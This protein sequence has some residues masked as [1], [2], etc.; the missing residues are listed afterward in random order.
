MARINDIRSKLGISNLGDDDKSRLYQDFIKTGGKVID[1]Q[2][3]ENLE[4]FTRLK[5]LISSRDSY[6]NELEAR[7]EREFQEKQRRELTQQYQGRSG[8]TPAATPADKTKKKPDN[9]YFELFM[10]RIMLSV[11]SIAGFFSNRIHPQFMNQTMIDLKNALLNSRSILA[12]VLYQDRALSSQIKERLNAIA[13]HYYYELVFR[14]DTT[15]DDTHFRSLAGLKL[16]KRQLDNGG[17][18]FIALFKRLYLLAGYRQPLEDAVKTVLTAEG[19]M[20][21]ISKQTVESNIRYIS[22]NIDFIF[23]RYYPRLYQLVDYYYKKARAAGKKESLEE[24]I[25]FEE[26]DRV[27]YLTRKWQEEEDAEEKRRKQEAAKKLDEQKKSDNPASNIESLENN[28]VKQGLRLISANVNF[29]GVLE[30]AAQSNDPWGLCPVNDRVFLI[31]TLIDF[32]DREFSFLFVSNV[33]QY[34]IYID[35]YGAKIHMQNRLKDVYFQLEGVHQ[36]LRNYAKTLSQ[37]STSTSHKDLMTSKDIPEIA[38]LNAYREE[39]LRIVLLDSRKIF[40]NFVKIFEF[41][42]GDAFKKIIKNGDEVFE[43]RDK[44]NEP[45]MA[46]GKKINEIFLNAHYVAA[47]MFFLLTDADLSGYALFVKIP[48]YLS[49][50]VYREISVPGGKPNEKVKEALPEPKKVISPEEVEMVEDEIKKLND[51]LQSRKK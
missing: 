22:R 7:K 5:E 23:L 15:F 43:P 9:G 49:I 17:A 4:N 30:T 8:I 2:N 6:E 11:N 33:V 39:I 40:E 31:N 18:P 26:A 45:R 37:I 20:R 10:T 1:L 16:T 28:P 3:D 47:A 36:K 44:L 46:V 42:S 35:K 24:F 41:L 38:H 50:P 29:Q 25:R 27:G 32:F 51:I 19:Q 14:F 13:R 12:S 48:R 21:N 34:D